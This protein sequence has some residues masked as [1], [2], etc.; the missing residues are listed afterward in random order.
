MLHNFFEIKSLIDKSS[1]PDPNLYILES[2]G[3]HN[4]I[5]EKK[6]AKLHEFIDLLY[7]CRITIVKLLLSSNFMHILVMY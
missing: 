5:I 1:K 2:R 3:I 7:K 4:R 6:L